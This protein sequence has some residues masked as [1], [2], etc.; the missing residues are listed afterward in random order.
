MEKYRFTSEQQA[1][2]ES[3]PAPFAVFQLV[4]KR[5]VTI[6]LSDGFCELLVA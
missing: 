6:V 2:M 5:I 4:D 1:L 3:M